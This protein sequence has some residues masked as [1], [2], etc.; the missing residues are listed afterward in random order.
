MMVFTIFA[1]D[2]LQTVL[3]ILDAYKFFVANFGDTCALDRLH[4]EWL[5]VPVLTGIS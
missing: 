1:L 4:L 2:S 5:A 3:V